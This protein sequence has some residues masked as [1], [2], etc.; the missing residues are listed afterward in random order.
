MF[1]KMNHNKHSITDSNISQKID[2][3][4][5]EYELYQMLMGL[6]QEMKMYLD[7][8]DLKKE[9]I[10]FHPLY[11]AINNLPREMVEDLWE[12]YVEPTFEY[13][14]YPSYSHHEHIIDLLEKEYYVNNE[15]EKTLVNLSENDFTILYEIVNPIKRIELAR[16]YL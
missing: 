16:S 1:K 14:G 4:Y 9:V 5:S 13:D 3:M 10:D 11:A 15:S 8:L 7:T 2:K 6:K 12:S